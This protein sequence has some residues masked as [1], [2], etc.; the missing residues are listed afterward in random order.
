MTYKKGFLLSLIGSDLSV[1][2][3]EVIAWLSERKLMPS[4]ELITHV[5]NH[6]EGLV[7]LE[8]SI[9]SL[10]GPKLFLSVSDLLPDEIPEPPKPITRP[11]IADI[12]P[13]IVDRQISKSLADCKL[14]SYV[15]LF[16]DRFKTLSRLVRRDPSMRD[17]GSLANLNP[18]EENKVIGMIADIQTFSN[19]R[20]RATLEDSNSRLNIMLNES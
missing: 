12:P 6:P 11:K 14:E 4:P 2:E 8:R 1:K 5:M 20:L 18:D 19:G 9:E 10:E 3:K 7:I 16:N 17:A 15:S 13:V